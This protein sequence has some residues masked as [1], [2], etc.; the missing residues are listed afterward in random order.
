[1]STTVL[2]PCPTCGLPSPVYPART[3]A[4]GC[5]RAVPP[6][7]PLDSPPG[8]AQMKNTSTMGVI[9]LFYEIN[10][11]LGTHRKLIPE[12]PDYVNIVAQQGK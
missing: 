9:M 12:I 10:C 11:P 5:S 8:L 7:G 2:T 4:E 3:S 6:F 1:M